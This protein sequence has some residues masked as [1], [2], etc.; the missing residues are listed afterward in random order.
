MGTAANTLS[1]STA[2]F[3]YIKKL[4]QLKLKFKLDRY[5]ITVV[6]VVQPLFE[7]PA[8]MNFF[9]FG[10]PLLAQKSLIASMPLQ[11]AFVIGNRSRM[12][13]SSGFSIKVFLLKESHLNLPPTIFYFDLFKITKS[14]LKKIIFNKNRILFVNN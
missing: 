11:A 9:I 6:Q 2:A 5:F 1:L 4:K 13:G 7:Y 14:M 10:T 12:V 8:I 3:F